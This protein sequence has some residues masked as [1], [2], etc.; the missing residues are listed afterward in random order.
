[1]EKTILSTNIECDGSNKIHVGELQ[2][3]LT[4][5]QRILFIQAKRDLNE[6]SI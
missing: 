4:N 3:H 6:S 5:F 2:E 1:M